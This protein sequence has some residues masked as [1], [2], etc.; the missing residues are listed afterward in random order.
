MRTAHGWEQ[1]FFQVESYRVLVTERWDEG[2]VAEA[3]VKVV[4][5]G[6]RHIESAEGHG[7]VGALD[8]ALRK[9]LSNEYPALDDMKL[10]DYRV[11]VLDETVGTGAIVRVLIDTS[12]GERE[13]T[14]VGVSENIIEASWEALVDAYLYGLLHPRSATPDRWATAREGPGRTAR[15]EPG[16]LDRGVDDPRGRSRTTLGAIAEVHVASWRWAYRDDL[17]TAFL[18]ALNVDDRATIVD[19]ATRRGR[20]HRAGRRARRRSRR[21]LQLRTHPRRRRRRRTA[22]IVTIY[23]AESDAGTG[24]GRALFVRIRTGSAPRLTR[25]T[26][27]VMASNDRSRRFYERAGWSWDGTTS[28]H[29]FD[30]ANVPIVR[31]AA[32]SRRPGDPRSGAEGGAAFAFMTR[33]IASS[34]RTASS[35]RCPSTGSRTR[36]SRPPARPD[37]AGERGDLVNVPVFARRRTWPSRPS[38]VPCPPVGSAN[39]SGP[40]RLGLRARAGAPSPAGHA[41]RVRQARRV[42]RERG[43]PFA[44]VNASSGGAC[45]DRPGPRPRRPGPCPAPPRRS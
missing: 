36:P 13:W 27:W 30:C 31:Y 14:T 15:R 43:A 39:R 1:A 17:P 28:D 24:M 32:R 33:T 3:T 42:V 45:A 41:V 8:N 4:T 22:E 38:S 7:P 20:W 21:L 23:L 10:E 19:P 12:N 25:A 5:N 35:L 34:I 44:S 9:A 26:L 40:P 6:E 11:R 37:P 16:A 29:R 2:A 18:D